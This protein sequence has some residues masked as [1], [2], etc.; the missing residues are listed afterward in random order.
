M[1]IVPLSRLNVLLDRRNRS[2]VVEDNGNATGPQLR[3]RVDKD[4]VVALD[5]KLTDT[6]GR[7][8][9]TADAEFA[10]YSAIRDAK[11]SI[12]VVMTVLGKNFHENTFNVRGAKVALNK[13]ISGCK[14]GEA[15]KS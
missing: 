15:K 12:A 11:S 10:V 5:A 6:D 14:L 9:V 7:V 4:A 1:Y 3:L 8:A 13:L 2:G